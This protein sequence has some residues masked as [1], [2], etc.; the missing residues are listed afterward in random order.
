VHLRVIA[1]AELGDDGQRRNR[2]ANHLAA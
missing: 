2:I 1:R